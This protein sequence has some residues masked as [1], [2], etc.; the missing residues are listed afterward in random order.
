VADRLAVVG[1]IVGGATF[2]DSLV[3]EKSNSDV[4]LI[5]QST[6]QIVQKFTSPDFAGLTLFDIALAADNTFNVLGDQNSF[7]G[8]IVHMDL[9]GNTLGAIT[10]PVS[11]NPGYLSP[12]GF[13]LDPRD[14]SFWVPLPNSARIIHVDASGNLLGQYA[15]GSNPDDAAVGPDGRVYYS[16][17]FSAQ[18]DALDP[19]T[20]NTSYF[21][22]SPFPLDLTWSVAGDLWVGGATAGLEEF[23]SSGTQIA[24]YGGAGVS[25][26]EP[27][28]S[29]NVW[30]ANINSQKVIQY[31]ASGTTLTTTS[32]SL[33]QPGLAVLG[34]VP[35]EAPLTARSDDDDSFSLAQGQSATIV[36]DS[37]NNGTLSL[38]LLDKNG[39]VLATGVGGAKNVSQFIEN[40]VAPAAGTYY[41]D[42]HG[43]TGAQYSLTVTRGANF[44]IRPNDSMSTA[45]PLTGTNGVLADLI[46]PAPPLFVLD[47]NLYFPPFP[48]W[49]TDPATGAFVG[50]PLPAPATEPNNPFGL[51]MAYDGT[52]LYYNDG[53]QFGSNTIY[54]VDAST[55]QVV[56]QGLPAGAAP[57]VAL[58]YFNGELYGVPDYFATHKA[59]MYVID[60]STFQVIT[61]IPLGVNNPNIVGLAG[62]PTTGTLF[63]VAQP[64][65]TGGELIEIDPATGNT[66]ASAPDNAQGA[67]EQDLAYAG[68]LLIVSDTYG[69]G[70]GKNF[71]DEYDPSTFA[72]VRRVAVATQ[73]FVSGLGGDG[74][75]GAKQDDQWYSVNVQA[76]QS[77][78]LQSSTP[79]DA[80][81]QFPNSASVEIELYD[82]YG[83]LVAVGTKLPDG[84]NES[85]FFNAP[86]TGRYYVHVYNDPGGFGEYFLQVQTASYPSGSASG[87]VFNDLNGNGSLDAGDPGLPGWT[88]DLYDA[89]G[90]LVAAQTTD[91]NGDF[92]F[93]GLAPGTYT[94]VEV[95]QAGWTQ[96][97]PPSPGTFTFSVTA[98]GTVTGLDFG[99]FQGATISG[100]VFNDPTGSGSFA[101]GDPG[102]MGWTIDLLDSHG[103]IIAT[104]TTDANGDYSFTNVGPGTHTVEEVVQ[105]GWVQTAPAPPGTFTVTPTS[106]QAT[107]GLLF[108]DFQLV[109][110]SGIVFNDLAGSGVYSPSDPG[111]QGWTVDLL[112]SHGNI[113]ATTTSAVDGS[114]SF[115][116]LG[117]G[118]YTLE[119]VP[120]SGWYQTAPPPPFTYVVQAISSTDRSGWTSAT[121]SS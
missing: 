90:N 14:G 95:I 24:T 121:S 59:E 67:S 84:R 89:N 109:T 5:D 68:G 30:A 38:T 87:E 20:G 12:E 3:V 51:N 4:A 39:N 50:S 56:A 58:A 111:L 43:T 119:E 103:N 63:A 116:N 46:K 65:S 70:A 17:V 74:L 91:K 115:A 6:G 32:A 9:Q 97:A 37:L 42:V 35:N 102:L 92:N 16:L 49:A 13:G 40:F 96:T 94:A 86:V 26:G 72:F 98:G 80:G 47:D 108:G 61:T 10:M 27:A 53:A 28:P 69:L 64:Y 73:G 104:T 82:T 110:F 44:Q 25:A 48:I 107:T 41:V 19:T 114:F 66:I 62:D 15:I 100:Q 88:V 118:T 120:Q 57:M 85:L 7:T 1:S 2:G 75:G 117:P 113:I 81:G 34:D 112:D 55:G 18:I 21:A 23:N 106:G 45:E 54:K 99:D 93:G 83:N 60:P 79:S 33:Y 105:P 76:G 78:A 36:A 71:L 8:V 22:Y 31:S 11:D 52:Y 29:G 101:P 77:L